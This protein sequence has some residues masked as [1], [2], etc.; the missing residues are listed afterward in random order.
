MSESCQSTCIETAP[1]GGIAAGGI[2]IPGTAAGEESDVPLSDEPDP[3]DQDP[4][5]GCVVSLDLQ[6][7][8]TDPPLA[9]WFDAKLAQIAD[10]AG[11]HRGRLSV[12]VVNDSE[13]TR[14]HEQFRGEAGTTDVLTFDLRDRPDQPIDA[15]IVICLD[16]ARRQAH[17]RGHD[18]RLEAL[19]YAV[20][21]L[22]HL[23]GEDDH[24][25][26]GYQKMHRRED[27]LLTRAGLGPV[28]GKD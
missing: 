18:T 19:L 7:P 6:I 26:A 9:G 24:D 11:V 23:L 3:A 13:M 12:V 16:E 15:D 28:F 14:L 20:H 22:M 25:Q 21:G 10:L 4:A 2:A 5:S 8:D 17:Q 27:E 1:A